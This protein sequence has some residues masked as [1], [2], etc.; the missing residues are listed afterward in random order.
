[1]IKKWSLWLHDLKNIY[2]LYEANFFLLL[3]TY[4]ILFYIKYTKLFIKSMFLML[5]FWS[6]DKLK[7]LGQQTITAERAI[8]I[9]SCSL[10]PAENLFKDLSIVLDNLLLA[11]KNTRDYLW[12][13]AQ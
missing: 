11:I 8:W 10:I 7:K 13:C 9:F 2:L 1:M 6:T 3:G 4:F 5:L 12:N